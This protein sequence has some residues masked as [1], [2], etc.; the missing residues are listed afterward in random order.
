[1]CSGKME[2]FKRVQSFPLLVWPAA[3]APDNISQ[4]YAAHK[5]FSRAWWSG[6]RKCRNR[7]SLQ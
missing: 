7:P 2:F 5:Y 6:P 3:I 4:I 1:M